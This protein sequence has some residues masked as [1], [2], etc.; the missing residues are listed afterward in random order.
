VPGTGTPPELALS[1]LALGNGEKNTVWVLQDHNDTLD[2]GC[3]LV[4]LGDKFGSCS[5]TFPCGAR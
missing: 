4:D 2:E 1:K 3:K 5:L